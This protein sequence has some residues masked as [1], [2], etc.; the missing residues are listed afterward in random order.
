MSIAKSYLASGITSK[1]ARGLW[2]TAYS[3][4][5]TATFQKKTLYFYHAP[6]CAASDALL[7]VL[8]KLLECYPKVDI[9]VRT[10]APCNDPSLAPFPETLAKWDHTDAQEF[11]KYLKDISPP[12]TIEEPALSTVRN[13]LLNLES[14]PSEYIKTALELRSKTSFSDT[15]QANDEMLKRNRAELERAGH[16]MTGTIYFGG[17]FYRGLD[18][19]RLLE[20]QLTKQGLGSGTCMVYNS[21]TPPKPVGNEKIEVWLSPR[22]PYSYLTLAI[23]MREGKISDEGILRWHG[24]DVVLRPTVPMAMRGVK[25]PLK[26]VFTILFDA[27]RVAHH[28][29]IPFGFLKDPLGDAATNLLKVTC[30]LQKTHPGKEWTF[31]LEAYKAAWSR[32]IDL[33]SEA[34]IVSLAPLA[35]VTEDDI[36]AGLADDTYSVS[37]KSSREDLFESGLWGVPS[38]RYNGK[39]AWGQDRM[40]FIERWLGDSS[41]E[42]TL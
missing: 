25:V 33:T 21:F 18:R 11:S 38:F 27:A 8:P 30:Y 16:W 29:E 15:P 42:L 5:Q 7:Q 9:K 23:I 28:H 26:K 22:S 6:E 40:W 19:M 13:M 32:A 20:E 41:A 24:T 14:N 12:T 10:V 36:R 17:R 35:G 34:N 39:V 31:L 4:Y 3:L 37:V 1:T 2:E